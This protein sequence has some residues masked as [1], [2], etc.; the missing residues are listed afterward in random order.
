M[1]SEAGQPTR[2]VLFRGGGKGGG[3]M[4]PWQQYQM[5]QL[6]MQQAQQNQS[7]TDPVTGQVFQNTPGDPTSGAQALNAEIQQRQ[8]NDAATAAANQAA[9]MQAA[10]QAEST[11]QTNKTQAYND[12]MTQAMNAFRGQGVDPANYMGQYITPTLQ[13]QFNQIPDQSPNI[14]S[15]FPAS[16][17]QSIVNQ[18]T[19]DKRQQAMNTLGQTFTPGY[20]TSMIPDSTQDQ[21]VEQILGNQFNP[22]QAQL[23]NAQKRGTLTDTGFTAATDL[24][25]QKES[26]ARSQLQ[27]LGANILSTDRGQLDTIAGNARTDASNMALGQ[28]FD[29]SQYFSQASST[30]ARDIGGFGGALQNAVGGTQF[31]DIQDLLNAGGAVQGATN[32]T[33]TNPVGSGTIG[34]GGG[35]GIGMDQATQQ[36]RGLGS[37]GAF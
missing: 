9:A 37:T 34:A 12:A 6:A 23:T 33:A 3:G 31:A 30:A 17:G 26:A 22:L 32:P 16:L 7:F 24:M 19:A 8:A 13:Q 35:M 4:S 11:F 5:Q 21:Y 20:S 29:P 27:S 1:F 25:N 28:S 14:G 36:K 2:N 10:Q 18:A 15:Y